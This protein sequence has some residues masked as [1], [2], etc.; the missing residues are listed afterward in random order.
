MGVDVTAIFEEQRGRLFGIAYRMLG[1]VADAEDVVQDAWVRWSQV[2]AVV[3]MPGAYLA[4]TV[5]NL[6]LNRLGSAAVQREWYVGP[7]LPEP[8]VTAPDVADEVVE[9]EALA[10]SVSLAMLVVLET[11]SPLE[12]AVFVL[13]EVFGYPHAEI[14]LALDRSES[15]VRQLARRAK[16]HVQARRPRFGTT[17]E[18]QHRVTEEFLAACV[19]GELGVVMEL[20]APDV[21][22]WSDGGGRNSA[23][24]RPVR[25][26]ENVAR[27]LLGV[28]RK[29]GSQFMVHPATV[30]GRPGAVVTFHGLVNTVSSLEVADGRIREV[31]ILRNPDKLQHV[32][33]PGR[34]G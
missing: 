32:R 9:G 4:R 34:P 22:V 26:A 24:L 3:E 21:T 29:L 25:G 1:T 14:A 23:A 11:L 7:W 17:P 13:R 30:N 27:F 6:A 15:A 2:T 5:T 10:E 18:E 16:S 12:R 20:L 8:L 33:V 19:G 31:Y 28:T